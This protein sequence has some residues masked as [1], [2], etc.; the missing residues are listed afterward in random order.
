MVKQSQGS[1]GTKQRCDFWHNKIWQNIQ[2]S[3]EYFVTFF[4]NKTVYK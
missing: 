4:D 1:I 3:I 2:F